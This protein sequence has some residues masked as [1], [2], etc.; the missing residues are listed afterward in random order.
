[1]HSLRGETAYQGKDIMMHMKIHSTGS[2]FNNRFVIAVCDENLIGKTLKDGKISITIS[3][4]FYKGE[5]KTEKEIIAVLK[6]ATNINFVGKE[7]VAAGIKAGIITKSNII[8]I[9]GVPHAQAVS[10]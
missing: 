9:K 7:S 2:R 6:D 1:M 8:K 3:K 4:R 10:S 5:K